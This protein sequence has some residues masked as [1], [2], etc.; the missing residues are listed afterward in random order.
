MGERGYTLAFVFAGA[1]LE[2][3]I[4]PSFGAAFDFFY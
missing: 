4:F 1:F 2:G 3:A